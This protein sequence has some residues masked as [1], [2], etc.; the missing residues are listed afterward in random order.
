M[1]KIQLQVGKRYVCRDGLITGQLQTHASYGTTYPFRCP[2]SGGLYA[3]NGEYIVGHSEHRRTIV[4]EYAEPQ[5][6]SKAIDDGAP[7]LDGSELF[8]NQVDDVL[9]MVGDLLKSKNKAYGNSALD[10]IRVFSKADPVEQLNVRIDDKLSRIMR[11]TD[12]GEDTELDL[13]GYLVIRRIA[14]GGDK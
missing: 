6:A 12:S 4:C 13:I 5:E 3:A 8:L 11:G 2:L 7:R 14:K 1:S 9:A 10:P